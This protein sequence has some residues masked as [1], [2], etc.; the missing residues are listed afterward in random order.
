MLSISVVILVAKSCPT[1]VTPRTVACQ[2]SLLVGFPRQEYRSGLPFPSPGDLP[3]PRNRTRVSCIAGIFFTNWIT[4][5]ISNFL[6]YLGLFLRFS[7]CLF[8][9][10]VYSGA[11]IILL[12]CGKFIVCFNIYLSYFLLHRYNIFRFAWESCYDLVPWFL[13]QAW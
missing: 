9:L 6:V 12:N 1:L 5:E 4:S 7:L 11:S 13:L 3:W 8:P 2:A 10:S